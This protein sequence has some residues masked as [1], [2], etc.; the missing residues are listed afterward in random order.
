MRG[1]VRAHDIGDGEGVGGCLDGSVCEDNGRCVGECKRGDPL[2]V[3]VGW[4]EGGRWFSISSR[5]TEVGMIVGIAQGVGYCSQTVCGL[6]REYVRI[7]KELRL[8]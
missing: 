1:E 6:G 2:G 5:Y 7:G 4:G 3:P 8:S